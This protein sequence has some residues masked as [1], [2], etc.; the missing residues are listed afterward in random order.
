MRGEDRFAEMMRSDFQLW[1]VDKVDAGIV[2][3]AGQIVCTDAGRW[4][5]QREFN[6]RLTIRF[7]ELGLRIATPVQTVYSHV[8][9]EAA[10]PAVQDASDTP[11]G[12][13]RESPPPAAL[14]NTS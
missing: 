7:K 10:K 4:A 3:I 6:R 12:Q 11:S 9:T 1:G 5:V 8:A 13:L 14:G 2:T